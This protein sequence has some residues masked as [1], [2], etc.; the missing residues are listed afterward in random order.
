M[1]VD[2]CDLSVEMSLWWYRELLNGV[3]LMVSA[4]YLTVAL[5]LEEIGGACW[6]LMSVVY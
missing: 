1:R 3:I 5:W 4:R 2:G 6:Y